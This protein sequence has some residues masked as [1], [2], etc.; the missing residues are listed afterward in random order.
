MHI[1][2]S[3]KITSSKVNLSKWDHLFTE[4]KINRSVRKVT[5]KRAHLLYLAHTEIHKA[6]LLFP[7]LS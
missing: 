3:L 2:S 6:S 7:V 4:A 5:E 1:I